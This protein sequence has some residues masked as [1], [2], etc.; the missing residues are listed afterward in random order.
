MSPDV[1]RRRSSDDGVERARAVDALQLARTSSLET[2][3]RPL[4]EVSGRL[5]DENLPGSR[6]AEHARCEMD[7]DAPE[8]L[9]PLDLSRVDPRADPSQKS[10][11]AQVFA[12]GPEG[13][14][15]A[16]PLIVA[17]GCCASMFVSARLA[18]VRGRNSNVRLRQTMR[19]LNGPMTPSNS[20]S[21]G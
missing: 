11:G 19:T 13:R 10:A 20:F 2:K 5:R 21:T 15:R 14:R 8:L 12:N 17:L 1:G 3:T 16:Q 7:C 18:S 4:D 6:L 9:C